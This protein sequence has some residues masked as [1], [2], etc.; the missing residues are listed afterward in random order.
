MPARTRGQSIP[1]EET[2][3]AEGPK[4]ELAQRV[5]VAGQRGGGFV[6]EGV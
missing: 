2:A 1:G 6:S 5:G 4:R 3:D